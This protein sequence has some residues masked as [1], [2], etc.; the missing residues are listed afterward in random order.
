MSLVTRCARSQ[1]DEDNTRKS[2]V[3]IMSTATPLQLPSNIHWQHWVERWDRMQERYLVRRDERIR[4][5]T[6]LSAHSLLKEC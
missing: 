5:L 6:R 1:L 2:T 3:A 4:L